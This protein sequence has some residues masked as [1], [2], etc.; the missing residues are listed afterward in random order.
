[1]TRGARVLRVKGKDAW[2]TVGVIDPL[3]APA[4]RAALGARVVTPNRLSAASAAV[5]V[6]AGASFAAEQLVGGA[7]LF[8]LSFLLDCMDGKVAHSRGQASR[9]GG[10]VDSVTD[11]LRVVACFA[12]LAYA[13]ADDAGFD[14]ADVVAVALYPVLAYTVILTGKAWPDRSPTAPLELPA[15][16]SAFLR[17][18]PRRAGSPF[19]GVDGEA[20][21][22]TLAPLAGEPVVGLWVAVAFNAF[23]LLA[24]AAL[25]VRRVYAHRRETTGAPGAGN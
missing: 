10:Y 19:S 23:H 12:G 7:L 22:F 17:A 13:I 2:W 16:S 4:I 24:S 11:A 5:A 15:S 6:V 3:A 8:Q 20:V 18:A 1:M 21:L 9:Y 14:R 25:R